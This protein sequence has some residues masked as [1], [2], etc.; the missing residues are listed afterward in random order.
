M[1][2]TPTQSPVATAAPLRRHGLVATG[3]VAAV[4]AAV[5]T[6]LVAVIGKAAGVDFADSSGEEIPLFAFAQLTL[7]FSLIGLAVAAGIR[8]WAKRPATTFLRTALTLTA[9]SLVPPFL[10]G[11]DLASSACLVVAHLTAA[12]IV[13]P[14][15][16]RRLAD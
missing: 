13:I 6:T 11:L 14:T 8:R 7:T 16:T 10:I 9:I 1:T 5:A 12:A 15:L 2:T 3:L 4:T